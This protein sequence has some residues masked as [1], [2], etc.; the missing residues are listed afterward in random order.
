[1]KIMDCMRFRVDLMGFRTVKDSTVTLCAF[2]GIL[3]CVF[4]VSRW[5]ICAFDVSMVCDS[6]RQYGDCITI[7][8]YGDCV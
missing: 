8:Q 2:D 5:I 4:D 3:R 6:E 7:R 1:M